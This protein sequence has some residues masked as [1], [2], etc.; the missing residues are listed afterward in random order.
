MSASEGDPGQP[1]WEGQR[2][3][4]VS[5]LRR[6]FLAIMVLGILLSGALFFVLQGLRRSLLQVE[7]QAVARE[8]S[9]G[10]QQGLNNNVRFLDYCTAF[11]YSCQRVEPGEFQSFVARLRKHRPEV[12]AVT[13]MPLRSLEHQPNPQLDPA[14]A[15]F[16]RRYTVPSARVRTMTWITAKMLDNDAMQRA[17]NTGEPTMGKTVRVGEN[18]CALLYQC[19]FE[20]RDS[21]RLVGVLVLLV[22]VRQLSENV[23]AGLEY[24]D[25]DIEINDAS[26]NLPISMILQRM[27]APDQDSWQDEDNPVW[28]SPTVFAG[29]RYWVVNCRPSGPFVSQY[30]YGASRVVVFGGLLCI[31][32]LGANLVI[33]LNRAVGVEKLVGQRTQELEREVADRQRAEALLRASAS[34]LERSNRELGLLNDMSELLHFCRSMHEAMDVLRATLGE[35]F[36]GVAGAFYL[37]NQTT[38]QLELQIAWGGRDFVAHFSTDTCWGVR[39]SR[40]FVTEPGD[41]VARC[42]HLADQPSAASLCFPLVVQHQVLGS[43]QLCTTQDAIPPHLQRFALTVGEQLTAALANLTLQETLRDLSVRDPLTDLFNRRYMEESLGR[44]ISR[45][46]RARQSLAL[47]M[48]DIDH[49]KQINDRWGHEVGDEM[50]RAL[51]RFLTS[52]VRSDD[53]ACRYGGEEFT[54][55][56]PN[57]TLEEVIRRAEELRRHVT[58]VTVECQNRQVGPITFSIGVAAVP[59]HGTA[60]DELMRAADRALY[61]AKAD[62]RNCVRAASLEP[63]SNA[64]AP[65]WTEPAV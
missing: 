3:G 55:I 34:Q 52:Q 39:Q 35:L 26:P 48:L 23:L 64:G 59:E 27:Q 42:A 19:L 16:V 24:T 1:G 37:F 30:D 29:G 47:M 49:F 53:V 46:R 10:V 51:G 61:H 54:L 57:T 4:L 31:M 44:E 5:G 2:P 8:Y 17:Y 58:A 14:T 65:L 56:L 33:A 22:N 32:L 38:S 9:D 18:G 62:G 11:I 7:F 21:R 12:L 28:F 60:A 20:K 45:S 15:D 36:E 40:V 41:S 43:L 13:W 63:D 50:L 6:R 25:L